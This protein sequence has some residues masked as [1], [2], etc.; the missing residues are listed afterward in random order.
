MD[1]KE[2]EGNNILIAPNPKQFDYEI[3]NHENP[4]KLYIT[5]KK[6]KNYHISPI[7]SNES[8]VDL[9]DTDATFEVGQNDKKKKIKFF[10]RS[11]S[12][13]SSSSDTSSSSSSSSSYSSSEENTPS[14][15]KNTRKR[16]RNPKKWKQNLTK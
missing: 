11:S 10:N 3:S 1:N 16:T 8:D 13:S 4:T 9:S 5:R 2:N 7:H 6:K 14:T 15:S 12:S